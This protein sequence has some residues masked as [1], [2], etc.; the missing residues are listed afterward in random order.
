[1]PMQVNLKSIS[2]L[3]TKD[4]PPCRSPT[5]I[6]YQIKATFTYKQITAHASY[7]T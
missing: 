1:M 4:Q 6:P 3:Y 5:L 2:H 7:S